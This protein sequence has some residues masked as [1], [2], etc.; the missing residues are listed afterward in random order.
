MITHYQIEILFTERMGT[1]KVGMNRK[2]MNNIY[3]SV[4]DRLL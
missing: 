3:Q 1:F 4:Q 2:Y